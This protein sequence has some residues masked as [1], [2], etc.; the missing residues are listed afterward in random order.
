MFAPSEALNRTR[1][2]L[3]S[4]DLTHAGK[5]CF[6]KMFRQAFLNWVLVVLKK[7]LYALSW[8]QGA[9]RLMDHAF[10]IEDA[11]IIYY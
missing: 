11:V 8:R 5:C 1:L 7:L 9:A 3:K 10:A 2:E 4:P 6:Y